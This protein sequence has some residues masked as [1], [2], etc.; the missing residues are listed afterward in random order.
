MLPDAD[1]VGLPLGIAYEDP[2]GHR[3][4]THSL[5][6]AWAVAGAV[7]FVAPRFGLSRVRMFTVAAIVLSSHPLLDTLTD[8]GLGC[9][10][11]WPLDLTRYF[12]PWRPI[13]VSPIGLA[14]F[15]PYGAF[16]AATEL[17]L[18]GPLLRYA[19]SSGAW[20]AGH[21]WRRAAFW[22]AWSTLVWLIASSDPIRQRV[23]GIIFREQTEYA[24]GYTPAAFDA[25]ELGT[26][27]ADVERRLGPPFRQEWYYSAPP[28]KE[29]RIVQI[30]DGT[31]TRWFNFDVCTPPGVE[32]GMSATEVRA[33]IGPPLDECWGYSRSGNG[34]FFQARSLCFQNDLVVDVLRRWVPMQP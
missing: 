30:S 24:A 16:V 4:A 18:F 9:A 7:G 21:A 2:W 17:I 29:C 14:F 10:L 26:T 3:G 5:A 19:W 34:R 20:R 11:F 32:V 13:P 1:V 25:I 23:L 27:R 31:V 12:A 22:L 33:R 15:S 28:S 6:F 8:G